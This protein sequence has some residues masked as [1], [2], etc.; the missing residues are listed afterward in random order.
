MKF[1]VVIGNPPYQ[2][3]DGGASASAKPIYHLFIEKAMKLKPRYLTM[4]TPSR[5][6]SGGKG[7][8]DFRKNMIKDSRI[9]KIVDFPA[10]KDCF[11]GVEIKGGVSYFLWDREYE[12]DCE[13]I[14][15][16]SGK[17]ISKSIRPLRIA[18]LDVFIRYNQAIS[19]LEKINDKDKNM[20]SFESLVSS[21]QP[22]GFSTNFKDYKT[23]KDTQNN[24]KIYANNE[25][26]YISES[27]ISRNSNW[28]NKDKVFIS[29]AYG[30]GEDFPHQIIN[31]PFYGE[32]S[33]VSTETYLQIGPFK[34]QDEA[35]NVMSYI[36]TKFFRFLVMLLKNTQDATRKVYKL[37]PMQDF[38][39]S[40]SDND[41]YK[42]YNLTDEEIEF[43][44][45]M[46]RPMELK[47]V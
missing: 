44:E 1:D 35:N 31:K 2:L 43:I 10:S 32:K 24:I 47:E 46:I 13:V 38:S 29:R 16:T 19:I 25:V 40:W 37:V 15:M 26:G 9:S 30:A 45:S 28:I 12:G 8:D 4:I 41:L 7:L 18:D 14:T 3:A 34:T 5:W 17:I 33:S 6:F 23:D 39:K 21:R 27:Q 11:P 20:S 42:K 22:F 36:S